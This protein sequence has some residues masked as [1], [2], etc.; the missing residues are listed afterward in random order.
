MQIILYMTVFKAIVAW[1]RGFGIGKSGG[2]PWVNKTD[3]ARF[4]RLTK[5]QG[6][7]AIVMGRKTWESLPKYG[8]PNRHNIVLSRSAETSQ[9]LT[10]TIDTSNNVTIMSN[11]AHC[12]AWCK[13]QRFDETW[14]IGGAEIYH[15]F[16]RLNVLSQIEATVL[17]NDFVCDTFLSQSF[18]DMLERDMQIVDRNEFLIQC[19]KNQEELSGAY[20]TYENK[21]LSERVIPQYGSGFL[22]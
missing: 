11:P 12:I 16:A 6:N 1:S 20:V 10:G 17:N 2:L 4:A 15:I 18:L 21:G 3:L 14:I 13:Q 7:N 22:L 5:G 8:L 9:S 19:A